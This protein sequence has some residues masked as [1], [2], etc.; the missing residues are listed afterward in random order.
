MGIALVRPDG[1]FL[2]ANRLFLAM[3]GYSMEELRKLDHLD[4]THPDDV[5]ESDAATMELVRGTTDHV[6]MEKRYLRK[7]GQVLWCHVE[8]AAVRTADGSLDHAIAMVQ[9]VTNR[10]EAEQELRDSEERFRFLIE[11]AGDAIFVTDA[12]TGKIIDCNRKA[13]EL[14]GL[15]VERIIG[16]HQ[17]QLHPPQDRESYARQFQDDV[18]Q[19]NNSRI[20]SMVQRADGKKAWVNI[21][22]SVHEHKGRRIVLGI[23]HDITERKQAEDV[24]R[25]SEARYRSLVE[26]MPAATYV[27][28]LDEVRSVLFVAPQIEKHSGYSPLDFAAAPTLWH[29][30]LH[31]D[32]RERVLTEVAQA[33]AA[34]QPLLSEYRVIARDGSV[35]WFRDRASIVRDNEGKS[36]VLHGLISDITERKK[37]EAQFLQAQKMEAIGRLAGG[38]AHDFNNQ[39]TVIKGYCDLLLKDLPDDAPNGEA[40]G[41]IHKAALRSAALTSQLLAYSRKQILRPQL[42]DLAKTIMEIV[43]PLKKLIGVKIS[44]IIRHQD[45]LGLVRADPVQVQQAVWNILVNARDAMPDGG[46]LMIRTSNVVVDQRRGECEPGTYVL[47]SIRDSGA[48]MDEETRRHIFDPF[49]TTKPVGTGTGLGLS[50]VYGFVKQSGGNI[51][52]ESRPGEGTTFNIYLPR[53]ADGQAG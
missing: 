42:L 18:Q 16:M 51:E 49:F 6:R 15:P 46:E 40:I 21:I 32:D 14:I 20:D 11:S 5:S 38:I 13:S 30:I 45:K 29:K 8:I 52:V 41:Q 3:V 53:V 1:V 2:R 31:P 36:T 23:F 26:T 19:K 34:D 24:L 22:A 39:L 25:A 28:A 33:I 44:L 50:M 10:R 17:S 48:G 9:D 47:L 37:L 7:D 27:A 43:D 12:E 4:I 35:V